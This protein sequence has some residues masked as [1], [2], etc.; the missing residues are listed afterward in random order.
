GRGTS[1]RDVTVS[2]SPM[3]PRK[4]DAMPAAQALERLADSKAAV[5]HFIAAAGR[6]AQTCHYL[7]D[8]DE[9]RFGGIWMQDGHE[10]DAADDGHVR[11][12][13][14]SAVT[15]LDLCAAVLA[16]IHRLY[17]GGAEFSL[18]KIDPTGSAEAKKNF[19]ALAPKWQDWVKAVRADVSV[20]AHCRRAES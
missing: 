8:L 4:I 7:A 5:A 6:A 18:R 1:C 10:N 15:A 14:T 20:Q 3:P 13:S 12:A 9:K 19:D 16:R 17:K 2:D 11:W